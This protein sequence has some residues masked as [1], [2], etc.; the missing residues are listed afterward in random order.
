MGDTGV[1]IKVWILVFKNSSLIISIIFLNF[2]ILNIRGF[3]IKKIFEDLY[4]RIWDKILVFK[5][6]K[7]LNLFLNNYGI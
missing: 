3:K 7:N 4:L 5:E 6:I 1:F 2:V